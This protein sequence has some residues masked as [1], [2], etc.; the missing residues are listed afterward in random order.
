MAI[1]FGAVLPILLGAAI[2]FLQ[3]EYPL[4][5]LVAFL[6]SFGSGAY[7]SHRQHAQVAPTVVALVFPA[8]ALYSML[9]WNA[10]SWL[11]LGVPTA[12]LAGTVAGAISGRRRGTRKAL[13]SART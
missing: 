3:M 7:V 10:G 13:P 2:V 6:A 5:L 8:T 9:G 12:M 1:L 11:L 4:T